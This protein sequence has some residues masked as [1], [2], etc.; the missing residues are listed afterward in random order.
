M[1]ITVIRHA[2]LVIHIAGL[3]LLVD[4]MLSEAEAM[5]PVAN[6]AVMRR[7]PLVP[8]PL[9]DDALTALIQSVDAVLVTHTHR[10]HWDQRATELLPRQIKLF[11]QPEDEIRLRDEGFEA[12]EAVDNELTWRGLRLIRTGGHHGTGEIGQKMGPVSGFVLQ[13]ADQPSLY[14]AGDT[15]WCDEVA[16]ALQTYLPAVAVINTGAAQFLSGGPITM[17]AEDVIAV[18][19]QLPMT[20]II[21]V[22][23][24]AINHCLLTRAELG[25]ILEQAG[26]AEQVI[27]PADGEVAFNDD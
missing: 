19:R 3:T 21:A 27:I 13:A 22:H 18:C 2:T 11:C 9:D 16:E 7:I 26:V 23:M 24:E 17:T 10:D 8:L 4:P 12:A 1:Q 5:E 20:R 25:R 15:I 14:I 6:S